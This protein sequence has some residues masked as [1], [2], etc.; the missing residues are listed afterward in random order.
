MKAVNVSVQGR[1]TQG[2]KVM[3]LDEGD[4]LA[5][6]ARI[7]A[8]TANPDADADADLNGDANPPAS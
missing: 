6:V 1:A 7:P 3:V 4:S 5:A 2:V 8:L